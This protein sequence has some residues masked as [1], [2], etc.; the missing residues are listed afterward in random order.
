MTDQHRSKSYVSIRSEVL[1]ALCRRAIAGRKPLLERE[2]R[3]IIEAERAR[4]AARKPDLWDR[5][6]R[7]PSPP[8]LTDDEA[9][10]AACGAYADEPYEWHLAKQRANAAAS[11]AEDLLAATRFAETVNVTVDDLSY[12]EALASWVPADAKPPYRTEAA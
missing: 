9:W 2:R 10:E 8:P 11:T 5:I 3:D 7:R 1:A 4:H 6:F 12:V